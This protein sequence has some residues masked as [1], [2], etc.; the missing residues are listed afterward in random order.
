MKPIQGDIAYFESCVEG[1]YP[2]RVVV[3]YKY[4]HQYGRTGWYNTEGITTMPMTNSHPGL[5]RLFLI[6]RRGMVKESLPH[7]DQFALDNQSNY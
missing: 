3:C 7:V 4:F 2:Y 6:A 5:S 1:G